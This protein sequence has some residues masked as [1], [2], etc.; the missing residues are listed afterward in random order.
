MPWSSLVQLIMLS[1][2]GELKHIPRVF[3][4]QKNGPNLFI[5]QVGKPRL[6]KGSD[7][8]CAA[9]AKRNHPL[10]QPS[11]LSDFPH[12]LIQKWGGKDSDYNMM[13]TNALLF[14]FMP[15][16][17]N[18]YRVLLCAWLRTL[19]MI[20]YIIYSQKKSTLPFCSWRYE[21]QHGSVTHLKTEPR[22]EPRSLWH[23]LPSY[24]YA[25]PRLI[26]DIL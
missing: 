16:L 6:S 2:P 5:G 19:H 14:S 12:Y 22:S 18:I 3:G 11:A 21:A 20:H 7:S 15:T 4:P 10:N 26:T 8:T 24:L 23:M 17:I 25:M 9:V 13:L 1:H